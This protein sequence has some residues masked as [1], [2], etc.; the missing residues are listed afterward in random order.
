MGL[1]VKPEGTAF[2]QKVWDVLSKVK[3]GKT[4]TYSDVAKAVGKPKAFRAVA[5]ACGK[6]PIVLFIPCHRIVGK[7]GH[8]GG[9]SGMGGIKSKQKLLD[10][11][12]ALD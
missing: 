2:Q 5:N 7:N 9:Y 6:N 4:L 10:L 3:H 11:E 12:A 8:L 1:S